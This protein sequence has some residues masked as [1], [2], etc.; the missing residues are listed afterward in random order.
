M[1]APVTESRHSIGEIAEHK[2]ETSTS[3]AN[4]ADRRDDRLHKS[5]LAK[6]KQGDRFA[7]AQSH[8]PDV[9]DIFAYPPSAFQKSKR[10]DT[11]DMKVRRRQ[12]L[13][14]LDGDMY[15]SGVRPPR[16]PLR[17][18]SYSTKKHSSSMSSW[19][20]DRRRSRSPKSTHKTSMDSGYGTLS[21][22]RPISPY[23]SQEEHISYPGSMDTRKSLDNLRTMKSTADIR[24]SFDE[25]HLMPSR[26]TPIVSK[27]N[28]AFS[29]EQRNNRKID[30]ERIKLI[31]AIKDEGIKEKLSLR[32]KS[33]Q[34]IAQYVSI[35]RL[36]NCSISSLSNL[37][38]AT[39]KLYW[40]RSIW[41]SS[42]VLYADDALKQ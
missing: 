17:P 39:R 16:S 21:R 4:S 22:R 32:S 35:K 38:I 7:E 29:K 24:S 26:S 41:L 33:N 30:E 34:I 27:E 14:A 3:T 36:E 12:S 8:Y 15:E 10:A 37:M 2:D 42:Q 23:F 19:N 31:Q 13:S 9:R 1:S 5:Y 28:A 40:S 20:S 6:L 25:Q 11:L 18:T